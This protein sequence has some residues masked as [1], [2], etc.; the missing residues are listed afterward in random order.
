MNYDILWKVF[1][2]LGTA[3]GIFAAFVTDPADYGLS[4]IALNWIRAI[5]A[6]LAGVG[7]ALGHPINLK[8]TSNEPKN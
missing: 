7:G 1:L 8:G 4:P 5:S 3:V 6:M 2:A